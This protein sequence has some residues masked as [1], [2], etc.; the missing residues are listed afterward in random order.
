MQKSRSK[1]NKLRALAFKQFAMLCN[2]LILN[3]S[4]TLLL[5]ING[6]LFGVLLYLCGLVALWNKGILL[7]SEKGKIWVTS[8]AQNGPWYV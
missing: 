2:I 1:L 3:D 5:F 6:S 4:N 8:E 7:T